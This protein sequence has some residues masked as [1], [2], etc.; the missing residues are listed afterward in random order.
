[1]AASPFLNAGSGEDS[2]DQGKPKQSSRNR[3]L[4]RRNQRSKTGAVMAMKK[5]LNR[6]RQ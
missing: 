1:L 4:K 2:K 5:N 6:R 3:S